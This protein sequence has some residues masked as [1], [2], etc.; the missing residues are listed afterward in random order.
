MNAIAC[1]AVF[2][3]QVRH[4]TICQIKLDASRYVDCRMV[5][6]VELVETQ[7]KFTDYGQK[8]QDLLANR[9]IVPDVFERK[10]R[11]L[12]HK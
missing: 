8:A 10:R 5:G 2:Y 6:T 1:S 9:Y 3:N 12:R 7:I 4:T 11:G